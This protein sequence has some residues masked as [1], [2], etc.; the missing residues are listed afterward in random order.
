MILYFPMQY[1]IAA[2]TFCPVAAKG[3][4]SSTTALPGS[5]EEGPFNKMLHRM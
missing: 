4:A 3:G 1:L 5:A 2:S